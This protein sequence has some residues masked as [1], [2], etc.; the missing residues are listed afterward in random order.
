VEQAKALLAPFGAV[1]IATWPSWVSSI[2]GFDSRLTITIGGQADGGNGSGSSAAPSRGTTAPS[3]G[4][5]APG[6]SEAP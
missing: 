4:P 6:T 2:T 5:A 3:G 1:T